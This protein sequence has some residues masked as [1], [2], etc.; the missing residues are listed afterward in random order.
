MAQ[1]V[2]DLILSL[3]MWVHSLDS[4]NPVKDPVLPQAAVWVVA[5]APIPPLGGE[6]S[7]S[8]GLKKK[9]IKDGRNS[10]QYPAIICMGKESEKEWICVYVIT[11]WLPGT[12]G[13]TTTLQIQYTSIKL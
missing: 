13:I 7:E 8:A 6:L 12:A 11:E 5:A 10:N 1:W 3:R 9:K 2:K 4:L